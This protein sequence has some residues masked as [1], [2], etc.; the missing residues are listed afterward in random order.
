MNDMIKVLVVCSQNKMR[1]PTAEAIYRRDPRFTI[2][3]AG[4]SKM[5]PRFLSQGDL[6][7]ADVVLYM[8]K[9]HLERI[10]N[11]YPK[12]SILRSINLDIPDEY[13]YMDPELIEILKEKIEV[14]LVNLQTGH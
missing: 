3:S 14:I 1:S 13:Q 8:E 7:W 4:L 2:R 12:V 6:M 10:K 11:I 9:E 5:S